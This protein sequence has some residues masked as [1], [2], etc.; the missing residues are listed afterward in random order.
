MSVISE[1]TAGIVMIVASTAFFGLAGVFTKAIS[2][3]AWTIAGWR[4]LSGAILILVYVL[5]R[6]RG[7]RLASALRLGWRG[8]T[9]A[10]VGAAASIF[11]ISAFKNTAVANVSV[12]YATAPFMAAGLAWVAFREPS[13]TRTLVTAVVSLIGVVVMVSGGLEAG[14][15]FGDLLALLMTFLC[16]LYIVLVRAYR[17]SPTVWAGAVSALLLFVVCFVF[18]DPFD[19][20][21][22]DFLLCCGFG[23]SFAVA[24]VLWTE[25]AMRLP[26]AESGLLGAA[27]VG[28]AVAFA[29]LFLNEQPPFASV[30]GGSIVIAAVFWYASRDLLAARRPAVEPVV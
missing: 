11:F 4:G 10:I 30:I 16:A 29:W 24:T 19:I 23:T 5:W 7:T 21:A 2:A 9:L 13:P 3:D 1:R 22:R 14:R 15:L 12:A 27:E 20:S 6:A 18:V 8:W 17:D 26:P 25:G 28:F